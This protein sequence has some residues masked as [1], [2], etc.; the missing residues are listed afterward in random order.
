MTTRMLTIDCETDGLLEQMTIVHCAVAKDFKS[1]VV[2]KFGPDQIEQFFRLLDGNIIIGHNI[3]AFDLPA[4]WHWCDLNQ[5]LFI[6]EFYPQAKMEIDTLVMSRLLNPDRERP[7]G[8]P[9]KVGP[10][11]LKAWGY[12]LGFHKGEY[13][14]QE[15]AWDCFS[16]EMMS[17][18]KQDVELTELVYKALCK[19]MQE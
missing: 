11:S 9:Q 13:G 18:C 15:G 7:E 4:L 19:E 16:E 8:L 1:G 3:L 5:E 12:R 6:G 10:H 2:Y 17:Y 14:E